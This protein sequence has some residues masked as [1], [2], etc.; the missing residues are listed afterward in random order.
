MQ[1]FSLL[2]AVGKC[3][4]PVLLKRGMSAKVEELLLAAEYLLA[5]GNEQVMLCERGIRTF[6]TATRNT[7][8]LN[9]IPY[10]KQKTHL[11]VLVDPS[12]GTGVR[13]FVIPMALAAAACGADGMLVEMHENPAV[14]LSDGAQSLYPEGFAQADGGAGADRGGGR[15][16]SWRERAEAPATAAARALTRRLAGAPDRLDLY[17]ALS[18]GGR[19]ARH[20]AARDARPGPSLILDRAA[21]RIECRGFEVIA[22]R[23]D[24]RRRATCSP[25]S[26]APCPSGSSATRRR[27]ACCCAF[28][29]PEGDDAEARLLAPSPFDV[30]R[31][32]TSGL[33]QRDSGGAV[34]PRLPR[35]RRL[36]PCRPVRDAAAGQRGSARLS[37]FRLLARRIPDRRR[38]RPRPAPASAPPS[39]PATARPTSAP[40]TARPSGSPTSPRAA[41]RRSRRSPPRRSATAAPEPA[42]DLDDEAYAAVVARMKEH[43]LAGDIY[44]IVPSRTFRAPCAD[45]LAAFAAL[46]ALDRSPYMFFVAGPDHL[47]VRR[48]A[49][50]LGPRSATRARRPMVEVKPIAGTRPRGADWRRGRP[51]GGRPAPRRQGGGRAYD[52][53]RPRPQRRRPGQQSPA[54][55]ASR[56]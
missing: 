47:A 2:R 31:A 50:S 3:G 20:V 29:P 11:P 25:R 6:E 19:R 44:Q 42:T 54:P 23:P 15:A 14:A 5:A 28:P 22:R 4:K 46:R 16:R 53:G 36:R 21:V 18:D 40:I 52:A 1:N 48:L 33:A 24:R 41:S 17:A 12:H 34:H 38:A 8:D 39:A 27:A 35:H 55:G 56:S 7:L 10:I 45:P 37:R 32:L 26:P 30:L 49:R 9:A 13:D 43:I 51:D